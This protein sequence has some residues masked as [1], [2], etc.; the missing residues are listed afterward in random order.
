MWLETGKETVDHVE[1]FFICM[2]VMKMFLVKGGGAG[3]DSGEFFLMNFEL[4]TFPCIEMIELSIHTE[5]ASFGVI[6]ALFI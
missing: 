6:L 2:I 4:L 5:N 3:R 1:V